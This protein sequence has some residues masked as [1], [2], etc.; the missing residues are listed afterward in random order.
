MVKLKAKFFYAMVK[1]RTF[2]H[3]FADRIVDVANGANVSAAAVQVAKDAGLRVSA[4]GIVAGRT[5]FAE[6]PRVCRAL[7]CF[8]TLT[9]TWKLISNELPLTSTAD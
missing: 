4:Q 1:I 8:G 3:P 9:S 7:A 2:I 6:H 5:G